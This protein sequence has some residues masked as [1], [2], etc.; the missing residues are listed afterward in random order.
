M[1]FDATEIGGGWQE[2]CAYGTAVKVRPAE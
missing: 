2:T 1:R